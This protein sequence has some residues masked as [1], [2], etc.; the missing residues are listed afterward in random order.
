MDAACKH[1]GFEMAGKRL[2]VGVH[3]GDGPPPG[4]SWNVLII[5]FVYDEAMK[6]LDEAQYAHLAEQIQTIA[7]EDDPTRSL[8]VSIDA[9]EDFYELRDKGGILRGLNV[10]VFYYVDKVTR[11]IV[12]VGAIAKKNDGQTPQTVKIRIRRRVRAYIRGEYGTAA[13]NSERA[14]ALPTQEEAGP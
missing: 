3:Q 11:S 12:V 1:G 14:S 7:F 13:I 4:Y 8:I 5:D 2:K 6:F 9:I 10:R